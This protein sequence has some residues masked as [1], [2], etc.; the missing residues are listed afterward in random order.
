MSPQTIVAIVGAIATI[1]AA[2]LGLLGKSCELDEKTKTPSNFT[3]GSQSPIVAASGSV[4]INYGVPTEFLNSWAAEMRLKGTSDA[5][6]KQVLQRIAGDV[7]ALRSELA[8]RA[9]YDPVSAALLPYI[10]R[11]DFHGATEL[12]APSF[13]KRRESIVN[14]SETPSVPGARSQLLTADI[15]NET[16]SSQPAPSSTQ[17]RNREPDN[18]GNRS[19]MNV[20]QFTSSADRILVIE[21]LAVPCA[22]LPG[23]IYSASGSDWAATGIEFE[24]PM[25]LKKGDSLLFRINGT[26]ENIVI[27]LLPT[28]ADPSSPTGVIGQVRKIPM[29]QVLRTTLKED[30]PNVTQLSVHSGNDAWGINLGSNNGTAH[31]LCVDLERQ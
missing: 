5:E 31:L 15:S 30:H 28:F 10:A 23:Y 11:R 7:Q 2:G 13:T 3:G 12:L 8:S 19:P 6:I 17:R 16:L 18:W 14:G 22:G 24:R 26:A 25:D 21:E 1:G 29:D 20:G 4:S 27:R 9:R